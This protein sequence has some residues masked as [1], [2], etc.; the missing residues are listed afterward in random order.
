MRLLRFSEDGFESHGI[1]GS[2]LGSQGLGP[3][4]GSHGFG[5]SGLGSQGM[6]TGF[7]WQKGSKGVQ[8]GSGFQGGGTWEGGGTFNSGGLEQGLRFVLLAALSVVAALIASLRNVSPRSVLLGLSR[9]ASSNSNMSFA[10]NIMPFVYCIGPT[11]LSALIST[12]GTVVIHL[13]RLLLLSVGAEN[14]VK[15]LKLSDILDRENVQFR[16]AGPAYL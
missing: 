4:L 15:Q 16:R 13:A 1:C 5:V 3:G 10:P 9:P 11:D 7:F 12:I 6:G 2:G 8:I 14:C